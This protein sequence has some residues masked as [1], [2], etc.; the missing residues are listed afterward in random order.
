MIKKESFTSVSSPRTS[1]HLHVKWKVLLQNGQGLVRNLIIVV[2]IMQKFDAIQDIT[3]FDVKGN[4]LQI[5]HCFGC[6]Q[7]ISQAIQQDRDSLAVFL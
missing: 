7:N 2:E 6:G 5:A 4:I 1:S 3:L